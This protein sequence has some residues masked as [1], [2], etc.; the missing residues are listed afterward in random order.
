MDLEWQNTGQIQ[1]RS[2][3]CGYCGHLVG[4]N[5]GFYAYERPRQTPLFPVAHIYICTYCWQPTFMLGEGQT[6]GIAFGNS[7]DHVPTNIAELYNEARRC[8]SVS[9]FTS[10]VLACR[11]L[12]MNVAV[13]LGAKENQNFFAYVEYLA[14]NGYVPPTGRA[15]VDHIRLR[16]NEATH[17]IEMMSREDA[18]RLLSF[19]EM[20][21]KIIYEFPGKLPKATP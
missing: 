13:Q 11:K 1:Q 2:F 20:L 16:G 5:V 4:P 6:P 12:L 21:L 14:T 3:T 15:W 10:S 19:A 17:E 7:V 8:M 9:A 18:E